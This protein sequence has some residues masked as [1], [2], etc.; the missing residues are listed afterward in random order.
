MVAKCLPTIFLRDVKTD[1]GVAS[2]LECV[3]MVGVNHFPRYRFITK[4]LDLFRKFVV[5]YIGEAFV[6]N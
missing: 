5:E 2:A 6:E 1:N 4:F 3:L